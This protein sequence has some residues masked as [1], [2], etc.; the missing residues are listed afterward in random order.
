MTYLINGEWAIKLV[1]ALRRDSRSY[2]YNFHDTTSLSLLLA[3][4]CSESF[5]G[6]AT[7]EPTSGMADENN[8]PFARLVDCFLKI[9]MNSGNII[10]HGG[11]TWR[12]SP[13]ALERGSKR[14]E[15][16]AMQDCLK[17][18]ICGGTLPQAGDEE[19]SRCHY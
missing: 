12:S 5:H 19:N 1:K 13:R 3:S 8:T 11:I 18:L 15:T 2:K 9:C 14:L 7:N 16:F 17:R 4:G 6:T 10:C